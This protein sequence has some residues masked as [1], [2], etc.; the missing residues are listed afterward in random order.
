MTA[1]S[2]IAA[3]G[4]AALVL[5]ALAACG[6][7]ADGLRPV[8]LPD[9]GASAGSAALEDT[10][11][12]F[13]LSVS[14]D[15]FLGAKPAG[16]FTLS[17]SSAGDELVATVKVAGAESLRALYCELAYD[18]SRYTPL[19]VEH[20]PMSADG[21][22]MHADDMLTLSVLERPGTVHLGQI[23]VDSLGG[24][25]GAAELATVR[26]AQQPF[27]GCE[28][29]QVSSAM[30]T[31]LIRPEPYMDITGKTLR[32]THY[33]PG[34]YNQDGLVTVSD[35]T[36][37]AIYFADEW[38]Y[39]VSRD[40]RRVLDGNHD[41]KITVSDITPIGQHFETGA[42]EY[43]MFAS[44]DLS[45]DY[46]TGNTDPSSLGP[47]A[48]F[49]FA[50]HVEG[51]S[52]YHQVEFEGAL[53]SP[54]SGQY[55]WVRPAHNGLEGTPSLPLLYEEGLAAQFPV[56]LRE[57]TSY[58]GG[59]TGFSYAV[60]RDTE[61]L[62]L[63]LGLKDAQS[64]HLLYATL[65]YDPDR[66]RIR[67]D[68]SA[69]DG[70]MYSPLC[71]EQGSS[72]LLSAMSSKQPDTDA[73]FAGSTALFEYTIRPA[74]TGE[75]PPAAPAERI[76]A[77]NSPYCAL[78]YAGM[79]FHQA[80]GRLQWLYNVAGD[81]DQNGVVL[82]EDL[83]MLLRYFGDSVAEHQYPE[84]VFFVD[85]NHDGYLGSSDMTVIPAVWP[86]AADGYNVYATLDPE[87]APPVLEDQNYTEPPTLEPIGFVS[88]AEAEGDW[89]TERLSFSFEV[90]DPQP[91]LWLWVRPT[92]QGGVGGVGPGSIVQIP[93]D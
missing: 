80:S 24:I 83:Q 39:H 25:S 51:N 6:G 63:D 34:D 58:R 16:D 54:V 90:P 38:P 32:W 18:A 86:D 15:S 89:A 1:I 14:P 13:A 49:S 31:E 29:R 92:W 71:W 19:S 45:A 85:G 55:Y 61:Y 11:A 10:R 21:G 26:F 40:I 37:L 62:Y 41:G 67:L 64:L 22:E 2:R 93:V 47:V 87:Q 84:L 35:L 66:Y 28:S 77:G 43:L 69:G 5:I 78:A 36:T 52:M 33:Y 76:P 8:A 27:R 4:L 17:V 46:P 68:R 59:T 44:A 3:G 50:D 82:P 48:S 91:G 79:V 56:T 75:D 23:K 70:Q 20:L 72:L 88:L 65:E 30:G 73:G 12:G 57:R 81:Y 53:P 7:S 60:A 74:Q 42:S 9:D